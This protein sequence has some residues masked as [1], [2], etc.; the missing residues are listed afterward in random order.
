MDDE[1]T[2]REN[3]SG[4]GGIFAESLRK[5]LVTGLS[6]V[7]MTEEGI[8]N[9]LGDIR[10][11][12]EALSHL[13]QQTN[14]SRREV[15]RILSEELKTFLRN[16]DVAGALRNA[17]AGMKLEVNAE[18]RFVQDGVSISARTRRS[19]ARTRAGR[20]HKRKRT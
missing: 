6:A 12:K 18:I 1:I 4:R 2:S 19:G 13:V 16:A 9:V 7:V 3:E 17:L 5:A 11:P 15:F 10:L 8:R 20:R 14:N